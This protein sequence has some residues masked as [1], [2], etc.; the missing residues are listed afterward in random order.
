MQS[1]SVATGLGA[2]MA[3]VMVAVTVALRGNSWHVVTFAVILLLFCF[4]F[5]V[6]S[7]LFCR[8]FEVTK[9]L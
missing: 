4:Y 5:A 2:V 7:L 8:Y 3:V 9:S 1:P 6:I